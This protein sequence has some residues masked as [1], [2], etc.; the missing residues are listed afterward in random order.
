V[1]VCACVCV[2]IFGLLYIGT[3][4]VEYFENNCVENIDHLQSLFQ[5]NSFHKH[6]K[7]CLALKW[8]KIITIGHYNAIQYSLHSYSRNIPLPPFQCKGGLS[9]CMSVCVCL[10]AYMCGWVYVRLCVS[11]CVCAYVHVCVCVYASV[12]VCLC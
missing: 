1:C 12:H 10:C 7:T 3:V 8:R 5:W 9:V 11:V 4:A 6:S 2:C